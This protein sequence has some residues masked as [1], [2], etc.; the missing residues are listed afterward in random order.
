M[1]KMM[2]IISHEL[3]VLLIAAMPL[4]EARGAIP[5]GISLGMHPIH[6][7]FSEII[8]SLIPAPFLLIYL[9]PIFTYLRNTKYFHKFVD[10]TIRRTL[11][12]SERVKRYSIIGLVMFV[13]VPLPTTGIWS[14]C[15]AAIL[16]DI[17][18]RYALPA[19]SLGA[20][21]AGMIMLI[22]T[23]SALIL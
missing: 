18:F 23:Y 1:N 14:G 4:I 10:K 22:L 21:I 8:G 13:A 7:T 9:E 20:T 5:I 17:P 2:E 3:M 6:A 11:K 15:L 16:F 19:I 12:K